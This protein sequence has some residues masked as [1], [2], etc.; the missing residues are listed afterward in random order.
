MKGLQDRINLKLESEAESSFPEKR[1]EQLAIKS[2]IWLEWQ[3][4]KSARYVDVHVKN[5]FMS[6]IPRAN[7]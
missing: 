4:F 3:Q 2:Q 7:K 6:A 1:A 5:Q